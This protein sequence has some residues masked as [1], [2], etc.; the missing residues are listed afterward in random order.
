MPTTDD[1]SRTRFRRRRETEECASHTAELTRKSDSV[2]RTEET[3]T[4]GGGKGVPQGGDR[5]DSA[6]HIIPRKRGNKREL[7]QTWKEGMPVIKKD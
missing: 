2:D 1:S 6:N 7:F 3:S 4:Y 5:R